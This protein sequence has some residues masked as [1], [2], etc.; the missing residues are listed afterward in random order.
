MVRMKLAL[1]V[2]SSQLVL[3][4]TGDMISSATGDIELS[5]HLAVPTLPSYIQWKMEDDHTYLNRQVHDNTIHHHG[6]DNIL[7]WYCIVLY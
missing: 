2:F 1:L 6:F 5:R 7:N 4:L 3:S